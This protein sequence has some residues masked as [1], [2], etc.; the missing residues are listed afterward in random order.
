MAD[1]LASALLPQGVMPP[2]DERL[3]RWRSTNTQ[4]DEALSHP[5]GAGLGP[6]TFRGPSPTKPSQ[7]TS[8]HCSFC[9]GTQLGL[10]HSGVQI[11]TVPP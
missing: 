11:W 1:S 9:P 2:R 3:Q 4:P 5:P 7:V 10:T 8:A 6:E